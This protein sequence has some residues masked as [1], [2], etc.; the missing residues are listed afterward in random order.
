MIISCVTEGVPRIISVYI[1]PIALR[2]LFLDKLQSA[3]RKPIKIP[4][5]TATIDTLIVTPIPLIRS[6]YLSSLIKQRA[7]VSAISAVQLF[8]NNRLSLHN[9]MIMQF[10]FLFIPRYAL[11]FSTFTPNCN[12]IF[13]HLKGYFYAKLIYFVQKC[14]LISSFILSHDHLED[15]HDQNQY[16]K[17]NTIISKYLKIMLFN[18]SHQKLDSKYR[19]PK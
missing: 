12:C 10:L 15:R 11:Y 19:Y 8:I 5:I 2:N 17:R 16:S 3:I 18:I 4:R 6:L 1:L 13:I 7:N 14:P 9:L